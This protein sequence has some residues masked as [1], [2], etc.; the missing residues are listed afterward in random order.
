MIFSISACTGTPTVDL[1][2]MIQG[3]VRSSAT[4]KPVPGAVITSMPLT[5]M[6]TTSSPAGTYTLVTHVMVGALYQIQVEKEGYL[7]KTTT[8]TAQKSSTVDINLDVAKLCD[9]GPPAQTHCTMIGMQPAIEICAPTGMGYMPAQACPSGQGCD[10]SAGPGKAVC[11]KLVTLSITKS[12]TGQGEVISSPA[13]VDCGPATVPMA[14]QVCQHAFPMGAKLTVSAAP[15]AASSFN[16]WTI[17]GMT[18]T[19]AEALPVT[20]D[21]PHIVNADFSKTGALLTLRKTGVGTITSNPPGITCNEAC[22]MATGGFASGSMVALRVFTVSPDVFN[23]WGGDCAA[24]GTPAMCVITMNGDKNVVANFGGVQTFTVDVTK[25]GSGAGNITSSP[26]GIDCGVNC[27]STFNANTPVTLTAHPAQASMFAGWSGDCTGNGTCMLG[28]TQ[29]QNVTATFTGVSYPLTVTVN[30]PGSGT[31]TSTPA[32]ISC[33]PTCM[34]NYGQGQMVTLTAQPAMVNT[35]SGWGGACMASGMTPTCMV[36]MNAAQT[37]SAGFDAFY[38]HPFAADGNCT[39]LIHFDAPTPLAQSC[40]GGSA[41]T[42][43]GTWGT[44]PSR[45]TFLQT[46]YLASGTTELDF[47]NT[48]KPALALPKGTLEMTIQKQGAAFAARG[49]G[50]L[51]SDRDQNDAAT[52]GVRLLV[53]DDGRLS[54]ETYNGAGGM[55]SATS[56]TGAIADNTWYHVAATVNATTGISLFADGVQ[57]ASTAGALAWTASSSTGYVG[58]ERSGAASSI[59]RFNGAVDELRVS[60]ITRY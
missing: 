52:K 51:Y 55:S 54:A 9:P 60:N 26:S 34:S 45:T 28:L 10:E 16:R 20:M 21:A 7:T 38:L 49:Y 3:T 47:I 27:N 12:G 13:G 18:A 42:A 25:A 2:G 1:S 22:S 29:N 56:P 14:P 35:F 5:D 57:V 33:N 58:A 48:L 6:V 40:G 46:A 15:Y 19:T 11:V 36:T 32:G 17:D 37:V 44:L 31:V 43:T 50:V 59:Y 4:K 30:G 23:S 41:P 8:V 53:Y 39:T 24:I